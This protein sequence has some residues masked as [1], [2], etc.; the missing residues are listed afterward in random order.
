V[1]AKA[2]VGLVSRCVAKCRDWLR[3]WCDKR[4]LGQLQRQVGRNDCCF[5]SGAVLLSHPS[6]TGTLCAFRRPDLPPKVSPAIPRALPTPTRT[7][8]PSWPLRGRLPA[9][10]KRIPNQYP[11]PLGLRRSRTP[12]NDPPADH[13]LAPRPNP[14]AIFS[15]HPRYRLPIIPERRTT[16]RDDDDCVTPSRVCARAAWAQGPTGR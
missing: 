15:P 7:E 12:E 1:S 8:Y 14:A 6:R 3:V 2:A 4:S 5:R 9:P 10:P 11:P 13:K 16:R